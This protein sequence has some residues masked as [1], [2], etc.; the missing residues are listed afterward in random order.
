MVWTYRMARKPSD[1]AMPSRG[2]ISLP[3]TPD[4]SGFDFGQMRPSSKQKLYD[5]VSADIRSIYVEA[6]QPDPAEPEPGEPG[7]DLFGGLTLENVRTGLDILAQVNV[8]AFK[9][10]APRFIKHPFKRDRATG[11]PVPLV[12]DPDILAASFALTEKQHAEL[13]PRALNLARKYSHK[14]PVWMREHMDAVMLVTMYVRYTGENAMRAMQ[15]QIQRDLHT[16]KAATER[17]A[18]PKPVDT[19]RVQPH[20]PDA[21]RLGDDEPMNTATEY[22]PAQPAN[23][24]MASEL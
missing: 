13:D 2:R 7:P 21:V 10:V 5:L 8:L 23:G 3:L 24:G 15:V 14:M 20:D 19:D 22:P 17:Q 9:M 6:G 12:I 4:G 11:K 1:D 16:A 18:R